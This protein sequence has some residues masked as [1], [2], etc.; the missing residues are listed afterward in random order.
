[1]DKGQNPTVIAET[2]HLRLVERNGWSFVQR[3]NASGVVSIVALTEERK[4]L[5]VEQFRP[6]VN[7]RVVEFPA[8]LA[9]D[10][11]AY[12]QEALEDAARRELLE[13][14]GYKAEVFRRRAVV[15]SSAG[16][17]DEVITMFLAEGLRK[18]GP[19]GG[20]ES[21]DIAVHEVPL[22]NV[23][24]WLEEAQAKGK[25]VASRVYAGLYF[26]TQAEQGREHDPQ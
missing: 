8:G 11:E 20:D 3:K 26:L 15:S 18:V 7:C 9:G 25:M 19:G 13:E 23:D 12:S 22:E 1:M 24:R 14:T 5:L 6:P 2:D 17:T 16:M 10:L 21:E 4:V